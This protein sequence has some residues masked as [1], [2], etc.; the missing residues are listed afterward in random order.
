MQKCQSPVSFSAYQPPNKN[1]I[2]SDVTLKLSGQSEQEKETSS[3]LGMAL[4]GALAI[5]FMILV[6][7]MF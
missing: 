2:P 4:L 7:V 5:I 1:K 3:F 6:F